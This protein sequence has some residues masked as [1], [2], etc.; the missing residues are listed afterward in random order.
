MPHIPQ[1]NKISL[2]EQAYAPTLMRQQHD[3]AVTKQ[4]ELADALKFDY[5]KQDASILEP[6]LNKYSEDI[7]KVSTDLAKQGFTQDTKSKLLGLRSQYTTDDKIRQVK[8]NY[9]DA[10]SQWDDIRKRMIQAGRP[11]SDI[12]NQ[13]QSF[14]SNYQGAFSPDGFK[15][16]FTAG[17]TSGYY[18]IVEDA[19]KAMTGIGTTGQIVG[20]SGSSIKPATL[21]DANGNII[22]S[23]WETTDNKTGQKV[24]NKDQRLAVEAYLNAEY[25]DPST[26]RGL[27]AQLNKITPEHIQNAIANVSKSMTEDRYA[28]LPQ[29]DTN[30]SGMTRTTI[31]NNGSD[32][33][34]PTYPMGGGDLAATNIA[35]KNE[36]ILKE[37]TQDKLSVND[38]AI[39][40]AGFARAGMPFDQKAADDLLK[41]K[42]LESANK[43]QSVV[44]QLSKDFSFYFKD[45]SIDPLD[46]ANKAIATQKR[47]AVAVNQATALT[48][49]KK[50]YGGVG[51]TEMVLDK[52]LSPDVDLLE[53][54]DTNIFGSKKTLTK[55]EYIKKWGNDEYKNSKPLIDNSG[56]IFLRDPDDTLLK[57]NPKAF[58]NN[59]QILQN[60]VL[61][62]VLSQIINPR[63]FED[64]TNV[65]I[66]LPNF[67][68]K[69]SGLKVYFDVKPVSDQNGIPV[70][71]YDVSKRIVYMHGVD[72]N[73]NQ[74][75]RTVEMTPAQ[76]KNELSKGIFTGFSDIKL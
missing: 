53:S 70:D 58:D 27:Y 17:R 65:P 59:V 15:N 67:R 49:D 55:G 57:V 21:K 66:E 45:P 29:Q 6:V 26:D 19:K 42:Q 20:S 14:F 13:K 68:D 31:D 10:M 4:M 63:L 16:E 34:F 3:E 60:S 22:A 37:P 44:N 36:S 2:Q 69:K 71:P 8:K 28:Q 61:K 25:N 32:E 64:G 74:V 76:A 75:V 11:G 50:S 39:L 9:S 38:I 48:I 46:A 18:D 7:Q 41:K 35:N 52:T 33:M 24:F 47:N 5:L 73:T 51:V 30:I 12:E 72:P 23:G 62:P 43:K 40:K 54:S 56:D 1:F